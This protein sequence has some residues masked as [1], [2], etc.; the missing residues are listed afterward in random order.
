MNGKPEEKDGEIK[1]QCELC[2]RLSSAKELCQ[3]SRSGR[4]ICFDCV[5]EENNCGC[6][7]E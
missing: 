2:G 1:I 4:I 3:E 7:D 6:S 5:C